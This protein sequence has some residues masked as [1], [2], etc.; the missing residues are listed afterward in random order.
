[1]PVGLLCSV[2]EQVKHVYTSS[3]R[4]LHQNRGG[5]CGTATWFTRE[6]V[7]CALC[8]FPN[9]EI[10]ERLSGLARAAGKAARVF[11]PRAGAQ[12][13]GIATRKAAGGTR[14]HFVA[15]DSFLVA[16]VSTHSGCV[17]P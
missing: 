3:R 2:V 7:E 17:T 11:L 15:C 5:S 4:D 13:L 14:A 12:G 9:T 6:A 16:L 10:M 1:M 8:D